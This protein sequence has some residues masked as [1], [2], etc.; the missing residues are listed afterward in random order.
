MLGFSSFLSQEIAAKERN[1][2]NR[3]ILPEI[4]FFSL[5]MLDDMQLG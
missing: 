5:L 2:I 4:R 3:T 1:N